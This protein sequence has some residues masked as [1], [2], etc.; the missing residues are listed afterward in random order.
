MKKRLSLSQRREMK[1]LVFVAPFIIG[2]V[3]LFV[4]PLCQSLRFSFGS[5]GMSMDDT[6]SYV[7]EWKGLYNY[8]RALF[9]ELNFYT[10]LLASVKSM[11]ATVPIIVVVSFL[12]SYLLKNKFSGRGMFRVIFFLPVILTSG[13][14]AVVDES[15]VLQ[16]L[17]ASGVTVDTGEAT[18][19]VANMINTEYLTDMLISMNISPTLVGYVM[20]GIQNIISIVNKSGIQILI[21]LAA[22]QTIS[23]SLYEAAD[24]EGATGWETF[25][26]ITLPMISPQ[27]LVVIVYTII[28]SF[29]D[30]NNSLMRSI[31]RVGFVQ[32]KVGYAAAMSWMYFVIIALIIAVVYFIVSRFVFY[33]DSER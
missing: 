10:A 26:K 1:G 20:N 9:E 31:Y 14:L 6:S 22:L 32:F 7:F 33:N 21:F 25:W 19:S 15:D 8:T 3:F 16:G 23:S 18:N 4:I 30:N 5:V 17:M 28:D 11:T 13:V 12:I 27:V 24:V 29:V 2:M